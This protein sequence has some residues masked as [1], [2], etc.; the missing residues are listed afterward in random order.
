MKF[1]NYNINTTPKERSRRFDL[2][3]FSKL[4]STTNNFVGR[5]H[6]KIETFRRLKSRSESPL[7][8]RASLFERDA[9]FSQ[10]ISEKFSPK[11][12]P[13]NHFRED[14]FYV[15]GNTV[16]KWSINQNTISGKNNYLKEYFYCTLRTSDN[17][18]KS[19]KRSG[20]D[21]QNVKKCK[22]HIDDGYEKEIDLNHLNENTL[23]RRCT[24][25]LKDILDSV[26]H[27]D[28][29]T[30][31]KV[32]KEYFE[33]NS[34]SDIV[35]DAA[36]KDYLSK[37]E[38]NDILDYLNDDSEKNETVRMRLQTPYEDVSPT[39]DNA[40][41]ISKLYKCR[42]AGNLYE[43][44]GSYSNYPYSTAEIL[45]TNTINRQRKPPA[46][47][48]TNPP[49]LHRRKNAKNMPLHQP[50]DYYGS[51]PFGAT[52]NHS[53]H[54]SPV[55]SMHAANQL[56]HTD[57]PI[58]KYEDIKKFC[59]IFLSE[60]VGGKKKG[61]SD[62]NISTLGKQ[63]SE[64]QYKKLINKFVKIRGYNTVEE[65]VQTKFGS[66][67]DRSIPNNVNNHNNQK[68]DLPKT[69][70][71][72]VHRRY[73]VTKQH[74][75]AAERL[76]NQHFYKSN[77][78]NFCDFYD[79][80]Q[81]EHRKHFNYRT[82]IDSCAGKCMNRHER[83]SMT[84]NSTVSLPSTLRMS[85]KKYHDICF[86]RRY[87]DNVNCDIYCNSCMSD[88]TV[89]APYRREY[90]KVSNNYY[91]FNRTRNRSPLRHKRYNH[92]NTTTSL[93]ANYV[94]Y[95]YYYSLYFCFNETVSISYY[96]LIKQFVKYNIKYTVFQ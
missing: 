92:I 55:R 76:R 61:K 4:K 50:M 91:D 40:T 23:N 43:S 44:L 33:T 39:Y 70:L 11:D 96:L 32:L 15:F 49:N 29:A 9:L 2:F 65:Y 42:S 27:L 19:K 74:F 6:S 3:R 60:S 90:Y 47:L 37:K 64:R 14:N 95:C 24:T 53:H 21:K 68:L 88:Y 18:K 85:M 34:Y 26:S 20:A 5:F 31:F 56:C 52:A 38:Y 84:Y 12:F 10:S 66:I 75:L 25:S 8:F 59:E 46:Y 78:A 81:K 41:D 48:S 35:K 22:S 86:N 36:F 80:E 57:Q 13:K 58:Q 89:Q 1:G 28:E 72:N 94:K 71:D 30:E 51:L 79:M 45:E 87:F 7:S 62:F 77:S 63:Y 82:A 73:H 69:Y 17:R 54:A 83:N 93:R 67:L 16:R